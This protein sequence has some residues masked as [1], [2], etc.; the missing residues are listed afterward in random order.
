M[1]TTW[2]SNIFINFSTRPRT[3]YRNFLLVAGIFFHFLSLTTNIQAQHSVARQWN[4]VLLEAIRNDFAR[5]TVHARNLFHWS[6]VTYDAWAVY[7][8]HSRPFF[9]GNTIDTF[10]CPFN[11][12]PPVTDVQTAQETAIS[13]ASFR[14]L[15]YR[16]LQSP[17]SL[18]TINL[19]DSVFISMG[20]NPSYFSTNYQAEGAAALGNYLAQQMISFGLQDGSNEANDYANQYYFPRNYAMAPVIPGN[21]LVT[22]INYWQPL[23]LSVYIDQSGNPIPNSSPPFLSPEWGNVI[24]FSLIDS[25]KTK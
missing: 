24:P 15:R 20:Y 8:D 19:I 13:Y 3:I 9:L 7:E 18:Y 10:F 2:L 14:L 1:K 12:V 21:P 22:N 16:F 11:G 25:Q 17:G 6:V 23:S 4:E 5:P